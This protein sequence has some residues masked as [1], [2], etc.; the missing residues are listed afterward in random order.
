MHP[1][2]FSQLTQWNVYFFFEG[3]EKVHTWQ[4]QDI[5]MALCSGTTLSITLESVGDAGKSNSGQPDIRHVLCLFSSSTQVI[6]VSLLAF[7]HQS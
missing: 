3:K 6:L 4:A 7:L 2:L 5:P 1:V